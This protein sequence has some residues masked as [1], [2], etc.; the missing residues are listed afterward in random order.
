MMTTYLLRFEK[1]L[2][3][4]FWGIIVFLCMM[5]LMFFST[6]Y[7]GAFPMSWI[8]TAISAAANFCKKAIPNDTLGE[9][10]AYG[11]IEGVGS[12]LAFLPNIIILF[13]FIAFFQ[14]SGLSQRFALLMDK[15]MHGIGLHGSSFIPLLMGFGCNVPAILGTRIIPKKTDRLVTMLM[16]P[17]MSCSARL[18]VYI[19]LIGTFFPESPLLILMLLY[20]SGILL[21]ILTAFVINKFIFKPEKDNSDIYHCRLHKP[22]IKPMLQMVWDAASE[23]L[24]KIGTVVLLAVITIWFLNHYPRHDDAANN[25]HRS[26]LERVGETVAPVFK[27]MGFDWK[28]S[29]SLLSGLPAKE[30]IVG[31]MSVLYNTQTDDTPNQELVGERLK[32]EVYLTGAKA[33][34]PVFNKAVA[35]A[36]LFF[37][38]LYM[39]CIGVIVSIYKESQ[40]VKWAFFT[41]FYTISLAWVVSFAVYR[42]TLF[43]I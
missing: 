33:G 3:H 32:N 41:V 13:F 22:E 12:V 14:M 19:L 37:S 9:F 27:P 24:K 8:E 39:P 6:F 34:K 26:Y 38:L 5:W 18:P 11:V 23:F 15:L 31:T 29:V 28:M 21:A 42:I 17:F 35:L 1:I 2:A 20:V 40:S 25:E 36:F 30:F 16:I 10:L 4:R 7:I 43:W